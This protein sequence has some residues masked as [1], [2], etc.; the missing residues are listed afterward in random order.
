MELAA[1]TTLTFEDL[2]ADNLR[3]VIL[4][5][6]PLNAAYLRLVSKRMCDMVTLMSPH[7]AGNPRPGVFFLGY[8]PPLSPAPGLSSLS[9]SAGAFRVACVLEEALWPAGELLPCEYQCNDGQAVV[10]ACEALRWEDKKCKPLLRLFRASIPK[11]Q[12]GVNPHD[13]E[14]PIHLATMHIFEKNV[15]RGMGHADLLLLKRVLFAACETDL[16]GYAI[17]MFMGVAIKYGHLDLVRVLVDAD[18]ADSVAELSSSS[19][20]FIRSATRA[21]D[22]Y[23]PEVLSFILGVFSPYVEDVGEVHLEA[24]QAYLNRYKHMEWKKQCVAWDDRM[25]EALAKSTVVPLPS[26]G[27]SP[28][29]QFFSFLATLEQYLGPCCSHSLLVPFIWEILRKDDEKTRKET[30][31]YKK[32]IAEKRKLG[33]PVPLA[34]TKKVN[35]AKELVSSWPQHMRILHYAMQVFG[36]ARLFAH[37]TGSSTRKRTGGQKRKE[38]PVSVPE[39]ED[40]HEERPLK[41]H[42]I[43]LT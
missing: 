1:R 18:N 41:R 4:H 26:P 33:E 17:P 43:D 14:S 30:G 10:A 20:S 28:V 32:A 40:A 35:P 12:T 34:W 13:A 31:E 36:C 2:L 9:P 21:R 39:K 23:N 19:N 16:A 27:S 25:T 15:C 6:G 8:Y 22:A 3:E 5:L 42:H 11:R 24:I 38:P 7:L 37:L 29:A